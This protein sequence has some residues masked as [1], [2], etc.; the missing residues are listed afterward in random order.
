MKQSLIWVFF[1][2]LALTSI[3]GKAE[4][5]KAHDHGRDEQ[6][7][8][9][10]PKGKVE[11]H[12]HAHGHSQE[13]AAHGKS[14]EHKHEEGND[15]VGP[16]KGIVEASEENGIKLS[17]EAFGNFGIKTQKLSGAG[18]WTI[19]STARLLSGEEVNIYR[20]RDQFI[21]RID[22]KA[23][24]IAGNNLSI[25]TPELRA[26]DEIVVNGVGFLRIAELVAFGGAPEGHSH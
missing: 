18:P 15:N 7:D 14:S 11:D 20:I 6:H 9:D 13:E 21:K 3:Y 1:G 24:K 22:F 26:G 19:P 8:H 2:I 10:E 4:S 23:V 5:E 16:D 25:Q 12:N 17:K